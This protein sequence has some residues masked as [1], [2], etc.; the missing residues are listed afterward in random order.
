M[1]SGSRR[2][3]SPSG[4]VCAS[5]RPPRARFPRDVAPQGQIPI[6][7]PRN[8]PQTHHSPVLFPSRTSERVVRGIQKIIR[9]ENPCDISQPKIKLQAAPDRDGESAGGGG[10]AGSV[11]AGEGEAERT[12]GPWVP[13]AQDPASRSPLSSEQRGGTAKLWDDD[14]TFGYVTPEAIRPAGSHTGS[15]RGSGGPPSPGAH[16]APALLAS[17]ESHTMTV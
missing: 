3:R 7:R 11:Q 4:G 2:S 16:A 15:L 17:R 1:P 9:G 12:G 8:R 10:G 6:G 5:P 13:G 14:T